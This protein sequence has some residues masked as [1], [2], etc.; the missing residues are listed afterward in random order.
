MA[1]SG[2]NYWPPTGRTSWPLT[3]TLVAGALRELTATLI[4]I[5]DRFESIDTSLADDMA[6]GL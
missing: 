5:T 4:E 6:G 1:T 2:E 3:M